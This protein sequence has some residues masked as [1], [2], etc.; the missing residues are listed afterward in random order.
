[1]PAPAQLLGDGLVIKRCTANMTLKDTCKYMYNTCIIVLLS[2]LYL[3][4]GA[5][6]TKKICEIRFWFLVVAF[7][8]L[9]S[10]DVLFTFFGAYNFGTF[11][12][13]TIIFIPL[14]PNCMVCMR[15]SA[16]IWFGSSPTPFHSLLFLYISLEMGWGRSQS[17][18]VDLQKKY[19]K[20]RSTVKN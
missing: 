6:N 4:N 19:F 10:H 20:R 1:M 11:F 18:I 17:K 15:F 2:N 14:S 13:I 5:A 7:L 12:T 9:M 16:A 3:C 8:C